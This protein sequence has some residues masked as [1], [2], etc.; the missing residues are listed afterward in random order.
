VRVV[1]GDKRDTVRGGAALVFH[2]MARRD[3][4]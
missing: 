4:E 3:Q 1:P 2:E